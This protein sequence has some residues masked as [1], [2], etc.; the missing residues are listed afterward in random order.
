MKHIDKH[1]NSK[2]WEEEQVELFKNLKPSFK[3]DK[4]DVWEALFDKTDNQD[5]A[6]KN[7]TT[8]ANLKPIKG[9][10][11]WP[12]M[13]AAASVI[14]IIGATLFCKLYTTTVDCNRGEHLAQTLPDGS[15][16]QLNSE[17]S[18]SYAPYWWYFDRSVSL[19]GEAFFEVQKGKKFTVTSTLGN[20]TVLGTSF[21]IFARDNVYK[22]LCTTGKV[23]VSTANEKNSVTL[24]PNQLAE[25]ENQ[26]TLKKS[27]NIQANNI[28][29]WK[30]NKF[31]FVATPLVDVFQEIER[32]YDVKLDIKSVPQHLHTGSFNKNKDVESTLNLICLTFNLKFEKIKNKNYKIEPL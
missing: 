27:S 26:T 2:S 29:G 21:N 6:S 23:K 16:V 25:L 8:T 20:T 13:L 30:D 12:K 31:N 4:E 22:V 7:K 17:S 10:I 32:Q 11:D 24:E 1:N 28:I 3:E 5:T 19:D 14:L 9:G 15:T 18:I